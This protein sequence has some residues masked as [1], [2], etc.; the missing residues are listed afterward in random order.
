MLIVE[1]PPLEPGACFVTGTS[2]GRMVDTL[3]EIEDG[4]GYGRLYIAEST[5]ESL[6]QMFEMLPKKGADG[7][8][9]KV[10]A[11]KAEVEELKAQL[12]AEREANRVLAHARYPE[13][14]KR[15]S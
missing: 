14:S 11:L 1:S 2:E 10:K 6:G 5:V 12:A 4:P 8:R 9:R 3:R 13:E 15:A 7:L